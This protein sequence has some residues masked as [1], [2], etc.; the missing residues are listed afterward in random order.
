MERRKFLIGAGSAAVGAS[1]VIG[2]GAFSRVN[3]KRTVDVSVA[4]D[5]AALL[6]LDSSQGENSAYSTQTGSGEVKV[7]I[8]RRSG[9]DASSGVNP[10]AVTRLFQLFRIKNQGTQPVVV[11]T[12]GDSIT[13]YPDSEDTMYID[14]QISNRPNGGYTRSKPA[15][16]RDEV[17]GTGVYNAANLT[18]LGDIYDDD[19]YNGEGLTEFTLDTGESFDF[20]LYV[21]AGASD[22]DTT[23]NVELV[24][25][26]SDVP[27][28]FGDS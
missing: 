5:A 9:E 23:Y 11:W 18:E 3:A 26:S 28:D 15:Q 19:T 14:P 1:A 22:A 25:S 8:D 10:N 4:G 12:P 21:D 16:F 24:A 17:S 20:G 2:S 7:D 13:P 6:S 27:N